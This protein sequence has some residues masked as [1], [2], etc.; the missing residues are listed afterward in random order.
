[1]WRRS[2]RDSA[3]HW[4]PFEDT[5]GVISQIDNMH[6]GVLEENERM[7]A[8]LQAVRCWYDRDGSV[9]GCENLM[10]EHVEPLT[11]SPNTESSGAKRPL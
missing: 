10:E 2:Y 1:M 3:P 8:A 5:A 7:R 11:Y 9:G 4:Q 6:A